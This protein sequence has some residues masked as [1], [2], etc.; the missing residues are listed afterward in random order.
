MQAD[1]R[2]V[3]HEQRVGERSAERSGEVDAL[4]FAARERAALAVEREI[5]KP[6]VA[7]IAEPRPH[8]AKHQL[9]R[10]I[11]HGAHRSKVQRGEELS[12]PFDR[13]QHQIVNGEAGQRFQR[14]ALKLEVAG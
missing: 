9:A 8:F 1:G 3:Q 11:H 14:A 7:Q 12:Q 2:L 6:H 4:H 10:F 13:Q 5:A